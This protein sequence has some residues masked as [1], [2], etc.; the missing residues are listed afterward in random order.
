MSQG[1]NRAFINVKKKADNFTMVD[2]EFHTAGT[3]KAI[4]NT[5]AKGT[6]VFGLKVFEHLK[7]T[8]KSKWFWFFIIPL[9]VGII[10][11]LIGKLF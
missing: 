6:K 10:T 5:S 4:L 3:D 8:A 7:E 2:C 1:E 9:V 11:V